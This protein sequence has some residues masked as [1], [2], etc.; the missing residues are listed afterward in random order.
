MKQKITMGEVDTSEAEALFGADRAYSRIKLKT[1]ISKWR[2]IDPLR[3]LTMKDYQ[4]FTELLGHPMNE[5]SRDRW[6]IFS[7]PEVQRLIEMINGPHG[8]TILK[9]LEIKHAAKIGSGNEEA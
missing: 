1:A 4:E 3:Y 7:K 2:G 8:H 6:D 5:Q 9:I